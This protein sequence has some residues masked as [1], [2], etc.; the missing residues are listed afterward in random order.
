MNR[1]QTP[2]VAYV[3]SINP[4]YCTISEAAES[5]DVSV[6]TLRNWMRDPHHPT[7]APS[8][9]A[10]FGRMT[11]YVYTPEDI[12]ALRDWMASRRGVTKRDDQ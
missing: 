6:S 4:D 12:D 3:K 11:I 2:A 9:K 5:L 8:L 1:E 7:E 10:Q